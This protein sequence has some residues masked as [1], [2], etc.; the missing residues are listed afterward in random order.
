MSSDLASPWV[1][2][3]NVELL[4]K[5]GNAKFAVEY[6]DPRTVQMMSTDRVCAIDL[7]KFRLIINQKS[8][9]ND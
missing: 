9:L 5:Q 1:L 8:G 4:L 7:E 3:A 6:L 2:P